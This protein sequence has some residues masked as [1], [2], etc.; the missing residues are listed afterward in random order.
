MRPAVLLVVGQV[1]LWM[2]FWSALLWLD[3]RDEDRRPWLVPLK[4]LGGPAV[5]L[6][7]AVRR[8]FRW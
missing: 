6:V 4:A 1:S 8:Y 5:F 3:E 7:R 2:G